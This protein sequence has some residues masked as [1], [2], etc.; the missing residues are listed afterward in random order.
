MT[1]DIFELEV[2]HIQKENETNR[3]S[4]FALNREIGSTRGGMVG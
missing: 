2:F 3:A 4:Y 1:I